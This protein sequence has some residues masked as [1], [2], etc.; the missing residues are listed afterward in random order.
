MKCKDCDCCKQGWF[1]SRPELYA[2]IG[3]KH[4]FVIDNIEQECTEYSWTSQPKKTDVYIKQEPYVNDEGIYVPI[5]EYVK[6]GCA[7]TYRCILSKALFVE[8]YNKWIRGE[9]N[10]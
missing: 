5:N 6:E 2:C 9:A 7:T 1:K 3:V 4:P 8:A 10:E